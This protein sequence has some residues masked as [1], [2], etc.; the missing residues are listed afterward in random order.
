MRFPNAFKGISKVFAA[1]I[2]KLI[3]TGLTIATGVA[4]IVSSAGL[5]E[6]AAEGAQITEDLI[7]S[8]V[9]VGGLV[10]TGILGV[11]A[12]I[13]YIIAYIMN[14]VG[15]RQASY[16]EDSFGTAFGLSIAV[17]IISIG[18]AVLTAFS[19]GGNIPNE[20][21]GTARTVCEIIVM[22]LVVQGIMNLSDRL[23]DEKMGSFGMKVIVVIAIFVIGAAAANFISIFFGGYGWAQRV[24]GILDIISGVALLI[25]YIVYIIYLG[26]AKKMLREN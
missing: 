11:G 26:K 7:A 18:T 5:I 21:A 20:I 19:V 14:L 9:N 4:G 6:K 10:A 24:D 13:L 1:E 15:L 2:L 8:N 12:M 23:N 16:D 17:L 22:I 25:G 3:A